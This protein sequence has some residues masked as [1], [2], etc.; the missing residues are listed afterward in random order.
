MYGI[1]TYINHI[2]KLNVGKYTSPL[3][4]TGLYTHRDLTPTI[5]PTS[6]SR[7]AWGGMDPPAPSEN[8]DVL[9]MDKILHH[10]G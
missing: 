5:L 2:Y 10:Q 1:S 7:S 8:L 9:L 6:K 4:A 3:D